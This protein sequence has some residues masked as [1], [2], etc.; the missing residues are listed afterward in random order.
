MVI[1]PPGLGQ[2][3][4]GQPRLHWGCT[5]AA[6]QEGPGSAGVSSKCGKSMTFR[7]KLELIYNVVFQVY[8]KVIQLYI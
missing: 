4:S 7:K 3:R 8:S 6:L 1:S 2:A 5:G